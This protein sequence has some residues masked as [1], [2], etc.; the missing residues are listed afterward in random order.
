MCH[1]SS[2]RVGLNPVA[3]SRVLPAGL[4]AG[5]AHLI[6]FRL[7]MHF[8]PA[9]FILWMLFLL[10]VW[11]TAPSCRC[12]V[13]VIWCVLWMQILV[14]T[15]I[16]ELTMV[17]LMIMILIMSYILWSHVLCPESYCPMVCV[18]VCVLTHILLVEPLVIHSTIHNSTHNNN[19]VAAVRPVCR[20]EAASL[21]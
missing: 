17:L 21:S 2:G 3:C 19:M 16:R 13:V 18:C 5:A 9:T 14:M 6:D 11:V 7:L 15:V 1:H 4:S 10:V 20:R 12:C 8:S